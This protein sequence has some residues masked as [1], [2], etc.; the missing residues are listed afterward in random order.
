M[1]MGIIWNG[2][3]DDAEEKSDIAGI[4]LENSHVGEILTR[5]RKVGLKQRHKGSFHSKG[6]VVKCIKSGCSPTRSILLPVA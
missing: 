4:V 3:I 2:K 5:S 6:N 1:P